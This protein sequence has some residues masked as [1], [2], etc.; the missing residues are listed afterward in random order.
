MSLEEE[1]NE[2]KVKVVERKKDF[3]EFIDFLES[4]TTW[5]TAPASVRYHLSEEKGFRNEN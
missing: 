5:L 3:D 1:Y 2:L 4:N